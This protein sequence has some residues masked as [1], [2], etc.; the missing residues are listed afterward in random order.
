MGTEHISRTRALRPGSRFRLGLLFRRGLGTLATASALGCA[1]YLLCTSAPLT[2]AAQDSAPN[3]LPNAAQAAQTQHFTTTH[4][5]LS[6]GLS[7]AMG[8]AP[9]PS[10]PP[11]PAPAREQRLSTVSSDTEGQPAPSIPTMETPSTVPPATPTLTQTE[12]AEQTEHTEQEGQSTAVERGIDPTLSAASAP[13]AT[14]ENAQTVNEAATSTTTSTL[15]TKGTASTATT[16][17]SPASPAKAAPPKETRRLFGTVEMRAS[18]RDLRQWQ[19]VQKRHTDNPIFTSGF[20]LNASTTWDKLKSM[21]NGKSTL[22]KIRGV[23]SFWNQWPYKLDIAGYGKEDY[24]AAP[25]EFRK[26]SGDCEDYAIVK[27]YTLKELGF[28]VEQMRIV[29]LK[30]TILNVAHAILAVYLEDDIYILDNIAKN[31]LSHTRIR[32]YLP[33]YSVNEQYRWV[34]VRTK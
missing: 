31:V 4:S 8:S 12:H 24:W 7:T 32:N 11:P 14:T 9:P 20:K 27:Y 16:A 1:L 29:V 19:D 25:Y 5:P 34:H 21:L 13:L 2:F 17:P 6:A 28:P 26:N 3:A 10:P 22:E 23:N 15:N 33:V 30:D 18:I